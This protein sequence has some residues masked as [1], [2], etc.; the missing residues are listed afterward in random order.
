LWQMAFV[1]NT[2]YNVTR[3]QKRDESRV[4]VDIHMEFYKE[5]C[6]RPWRQEFWA[7]KVSHRDVGSTI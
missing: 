4:K 7:R 5:V 2:I 6:E 3:V 1:M